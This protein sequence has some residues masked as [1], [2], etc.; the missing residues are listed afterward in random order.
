MRLLLALALAASWLDAQG[1]VVDLT[2][3]H[4]NDFHSRLMPSPQGTGGAAH[5]AT[6]IR[7]ERAHCPRCLLLNAGD[8]VQGSPVSTI[9]RGLPVFEVLRPLKTDAFVLGNHEFDYGY[10]RINDFL[11]AAGHPILAA[12]F[13]TAEGRLFTEAGH[14]IIERDGLRIGIVG[15][16]M[17]D[18]VPG[19]TSAAKFGPNRML[20][21][22]ATLKAEAARLRDQTDLLIA[23]VHLQREACDEIVATLPEYAI[24]I[25]GH[26]HGGKENLFEV[27]GRVG[28]RL[29]ASGTELGR[30]DVRYD[31]ASRK[32]IQANWKKIPITARDFP[33][34]PEVA[35]LV[36]KW[37]S[38]V[39][40]VVDTP[41]GQSSAR[42]DRPGTRAWIESVMLRKTGADFAHMNQGGVRDILPEGQILARHIWNIMPFDNAMVVAK[43]AG[44]KIPGFIRGAQTLDPEKLY[45]VVTID[46]LV[47]AW[48]NAQ[49]PALQDFGRAL[50]LDGPMLR[51]VLIEAV[52]QG[53]P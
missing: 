41:I 14:V 5:L 35:A 43:V 25:S 51:D 22:L 42:L 2:I 49:D 47:E 9:Y 30:L 24:T 36:E 33:P 6:A 8:N 31:Q 12:N 52:R 20:P 50:P 39:R 44:K 21:A 18:L 34:D 45:S 13:Q 19:F 3:L 1:S 26:D 38:K 48:R 32:V 17:E 7:R 40:A 29:R 4:F 37:E 15:V 23:L 53:Q 11:A 10:E 46:F 27:D 28:A 16:L